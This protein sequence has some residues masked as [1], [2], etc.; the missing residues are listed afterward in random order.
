M[1]ITLANDNVPIAFDLVNFTYNTENGMIID[2]SSQKTN[3]FY[4]FKTL[5]SPNSCPINNGVLELSPYI[6][7]N[8]SQYGMKIIDSIIFQA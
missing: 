8:H 2:A 4:L 1:E 7:V 5:S 6:D 3:A